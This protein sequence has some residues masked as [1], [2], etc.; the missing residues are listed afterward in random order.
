[1]SVSR[2]TGSDGSA[3]CISGG[4][5][6]RVG[7]CDCGNGVDGATSDGDSAGSGICNGDSDRSNSGGNIS[8]AGAG[9]DNCADEVGSSTSG[10]SGALNSDVAV[11]LS[12]GDSEAND[13][14]DKSNRGDSDSYKG[15]GDTCDAVGAGNMKE[16]DSG[17]GNSCWGNA[18]TSAVVDP[19]VAGD[20]I[21]VKWTCWY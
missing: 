3:E 20:G 2:N 21:G 6:A 8:G 13:R 15:V 4:S 18:G 16:T 11:G 1:M 10:G 19:A 7:S 14:T 12:S 5:G 9:S 17:W